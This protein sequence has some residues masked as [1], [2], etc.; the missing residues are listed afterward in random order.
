MLSPEQT[1]AALEAFGYECKLCAPLV[2]GEWPRLILFRWGPVDQDGPFH[3]CIGSDGVLLLERWNG[4]SFEVLCRSRALAVV[5]RC[6][7]D[8]RF[9]TKKDLRRLRK[10][11][12]SPGN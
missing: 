11:A 8:R 2:P 7:Q 6:L 12:K 5:V 4:E 10:W 1:A 3:L 9:L